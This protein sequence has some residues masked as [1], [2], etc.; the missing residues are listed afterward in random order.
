M[1]DLLFLSLLHSS[2]LPLRDCVLTATDFSSSRLGC[3]V[4]GSARRSCRR[5]G[6]GGSGDV[7]FGRRGNGARGSGCGSGSALLLGLVGDTSGFC[8]GFVGPLLLSGEFLCFDVFG[9]LE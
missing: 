1:N 4:D 2:V 5:S 7:G 3:F 9:G 6:L 8:G